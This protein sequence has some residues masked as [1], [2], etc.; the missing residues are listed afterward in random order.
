VNALLL[1]PDRGTQYGIAVRVTVDNAS[2][3]RL[4]FSTSAATSLLVPDW[5]VLGTITPKSP[6][7]S[8]IGILGLVSFTALGY[9]ELLNKPIREQLDAN[10]IIKDG[11]SLFRFNKEPITS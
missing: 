7:I 8:Q 5:Q 9:F 6:E 11:Y 1:R 3:S 10:K 4:A 2:L